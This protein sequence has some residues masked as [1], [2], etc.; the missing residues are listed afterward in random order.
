MRAVAVSVEG[1]ITTVGEVGGIKHLSFQ[2][3]AGLQV[4]LANTRIDVA[5]D[6]LLCHRLKHRP[7]D[8]IHLE[9]L[10]MPRQLCLVNRRHRLVNG[11]R[12]Q[13]P[14]TFGIESRVKQRRKHRKLPVSNPLVSSGK[15][16]YQ[17]PN[18]WLQKSLVSF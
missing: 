10:N 12:R 3:T 13:R 14:N 18:A 5:N 17:F 1:S 2:Q 7:K 6:D 11:V 4:G 9:L 15:F 16:P 8:R